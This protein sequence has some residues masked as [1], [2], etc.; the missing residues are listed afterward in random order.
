[1][2]ACMLKSIW[3][4]AERLE[5]ECRRSRDEIEALKIRIADL[6]RQLREGN[7][8]AAAESQVCLC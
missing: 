4:H 2:H 7:D 3:I 8:S 1:M 5:L 6:E